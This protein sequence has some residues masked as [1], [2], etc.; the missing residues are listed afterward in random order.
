LRKRSPLGPQLPAPGALAQAHHVGCTRA[1][2]SSLLAP[3]TGASRL[4]YG[5]PARRLGLLWQRSGWEAL[6]PRAAS[7]VPASTPPVKSGFCDQGRARPFPDIW[8]RRAGGCS[9]L[10]PP[11]SASLHPDLPQPRVTLP[12]KEWGSPP[13]GHTLGHLRQGTEGQRTVCQ[14]RHGVRHAEVACARLSRD[15]GPHCRGGR[16]APLLALK[17]ASEDQRAFKVGLSGTGF[18]GWLKVGWV[19]GGRELRDLENVVRPAMSLLAPD[20]RHTSFCHCAACS[21]LLFLDNGPNCRDRVA[22]QFCMG[23]AGGERLGWGAGQFW[24]SFLDVG[25]P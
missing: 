4:P 15:H 22:Q 3:R 24:G 8:N 9:R 12:S 2:L 25:P 1:P 10:L 20:A 21:W 16:A 11:D 6:S 17:L 19:E 13:T 5:S 7:G 14:R 23:S 18:R